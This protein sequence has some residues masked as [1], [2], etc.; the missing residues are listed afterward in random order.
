MYG[1]DISEIDGGRREDE[2]T[3]SLDERGYSSLEIAEKSG[4]DTDA[5]RP[6]MSAEA[7]EAMDADTDPDVDKDVTSTSDGV[8]SDDDQK[9]DE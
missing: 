4:G 1:V 5:A 9:K 6:D 7:R 8:T 2:G 3:K